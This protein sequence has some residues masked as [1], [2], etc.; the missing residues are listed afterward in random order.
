MHEDFMQSLGLFQVCDQKQLF[1]G[2][3]AFSSAN[4]NDFQCTDKQSIC[5]SAERLLLSKQYKKVID[6][7]C[8][9]IRVPAGSGCFRPRVPSSAHHSSAWGAAKNGGRQDHQVQDQQ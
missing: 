4:D 8:T 3:L 5:L 7:S 1:D 2:A 6:Y 9:F